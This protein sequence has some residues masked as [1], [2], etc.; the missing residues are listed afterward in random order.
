VRRVAD[1]VAVLVDGEFLGFYEKDTL[2]QRWKTLWVDR[3]P[4]GDIAGAVEVEGGSLTRI[5][6]GSPE[7][8]AEALCP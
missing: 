1:Y 3:E 7:K 5:V 4:E 2:L 8:T 6:S